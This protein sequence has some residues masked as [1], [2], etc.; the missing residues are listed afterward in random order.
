MKK[1]NE[2]YALIFVLVVLAVLFVI[3]SLILPTTI[4]NHEA[5]LRSI[6]MMKD[7][8]EA[9]GAIEML[10]AKLENWDKEEEWYKIDILEEELRTL[11][12]QKSNEIINEAH[13]EINEAGTYKLEYDVTASEGKGELV[14]LDGTEGVW[15]FVFPFEI[16]STYGS[17]QV[18]CEMTLTEIFKVAKRDD[19]AGAEVY[20]PTPYLASYVVYD[21]SRI[22]TGGGES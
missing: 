8:Y 10:V 19:E 14:K 11:R 17:S 18:T 12:E 15:L 7:K 21:I 1:H 9:Q 4:R 22:E 20:V 13:S 3:V 16:S 5:Q 6:Q 2:G